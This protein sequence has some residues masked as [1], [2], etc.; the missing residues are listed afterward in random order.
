MSPD[1]HI[2]ADWDCHNNLEIYNH[3][4]AASLTSENG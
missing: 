3:P 2:R 4:R 1:V